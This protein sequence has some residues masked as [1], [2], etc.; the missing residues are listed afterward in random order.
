[1]GDRV[2]SLAAAVRGD[3]RQRG[4]ALSVSNTL[5]RTAPRLFELRRREATRYVLD[6]CFVFSVHVVF[7]IIA[8]LFSSS[9]HYRSC[10]TEGNRAPRKFRRVTHAPAPAPAP[11]ADWK[12]G[13]LARL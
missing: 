2:P 9:C 1:M 8:P 3:F 5:S 10:I 11:L 12:T 4:A 13:A 6:V 7:L